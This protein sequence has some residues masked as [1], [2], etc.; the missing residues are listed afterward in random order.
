[1]INLMRAG[2]GAGAL[3]LPASF[4]WDSWFSPQAHKAASGKS[5]KNQM[6]S[7]MADIA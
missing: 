2:V 1:M 6:S 5:T 7:I 3:D 4:I